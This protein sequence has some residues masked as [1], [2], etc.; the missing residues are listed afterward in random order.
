[1]Q[2]FGAWIE[3]RI[4]QRHRFGAQQQRVAEAAMRI[5]RHP[6]P[7]DLAGLRSELMVSQRQLER[8]FRFWLGVSPA[9]Y[10]RTVRFQRAAMSLA[11]GEALSGTAAG[12]AYADQSH[13]NRA[14]RQLSSLTPREFAR[15][16]AGP[17]Q[18][19][20]RHALAGRVVVIDAVAVSSTAG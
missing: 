6:G 12:H 16:S 18:H 3:S 11:G 17:Q 7:V 20:A 9:V 4:K 5:Q 14:F 2:L 19:A 1:M 8:N 13:L 10:A 15:R